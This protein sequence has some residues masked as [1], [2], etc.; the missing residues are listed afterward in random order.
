MRFIYQRYTTIYL[1]FMLASLTSGLSW[2]QDE[3]VK[4]PNV[5]QY[6]GADWKN[7]VKRASGLS[8]EDAKRIAEKDS[9]I[10]FFFYMRQYMAL[11]EK[12]NFRPGDAVFFSG[13]PWYGSA[14]QADAYEKKPEW[15]PRG[16]FLKN[17]LSGKCIDVSGAPGTHNGARLLL[18]DCELS[19]FNLDNNSRTDQKWYMTSSGF[20]RNRLSGKCIDVAGAPGKSNGSRLQ[21]WDC[22]LSGINPDN[23]SAT[24]QQ[25]SMSGG[26]IRNRLSGKC[27][28]V[29]GTPGRN[30][31]AQLQL[32][33]C[34]STTVL[35]LATF[36][37]V[38]T[39]A[40]V[41][42]IMHSLINKFDS[43]L[44]PTEINVAYANMSAIFKFANA[45]VVLTTGEMD[46]YD[47]AVNN[48]LIK[49]QKDSNSHLQG[50][51]WELW[52]RTTHTDNTW[53]WTV[54]SDRHD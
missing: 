24:D 7:E 1:L 46:S 53:G 19:G 11:G 34:E 16:E 27:I 8:V 2:A 6:G 44:R 21:L 54:A 35:V 29:A 38:L 45:A 4:K 47:N 14:P 32:W 23:G 31:G 12:G 22:E 50:E 10:T 17:R 30:N 28:D 51:T 41:T 26:F 25:W 52:E 42:Y 13:N 20:I 3:W 49:A 39:T 36:R 37:Y 18:W 15:R 43:G 48:S 5:A 33:D 9:G 40:A